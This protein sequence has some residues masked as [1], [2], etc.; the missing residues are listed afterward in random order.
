MSSGV[1]MQFSCVKIR[2]HFL[3]AQEHY[4]ALFWLRRQIPNALENAHHDDSRMQSYLPN[5]PRVC[6][7]EVLWKRTGKGL[8]NEIHRAIFYIHVIFYQCIS[9]MINRSRTSG[10]SEPF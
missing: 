4:A 8:E 10:T 3:A 7:S 9:P 2:A 5:N 6:D 1:R